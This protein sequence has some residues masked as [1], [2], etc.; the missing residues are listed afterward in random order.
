MSRAIAVTEQR[1]LTRANSIPLVV[2][3][4]AVVA[5][6]QQQAA[7]LLK[8]KGI[9]RGAPGF[10]TG[11]KKLA[12]SKEVAE[13]LRRGETVTDEELRGTPTKTSGSSKAKAPSSTASTRSAKGNRKSLVTGTEDGNVVEDPDLLD[14][15]PPAMSTRAARRKSEIGSLGNGTPSKTSTDDDFLPETQSKPS[16]TASTRRRASRKR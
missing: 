2:L 12:V 5:V 10:Q 4:A 3:P 11:V 16:S 15:P 13:K 7:Q 6:R 9:G 1:R 14:A 8:D